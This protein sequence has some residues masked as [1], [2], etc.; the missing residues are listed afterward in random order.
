MRRFLRSTLFIGSPSSR[1]GFPRSDTGWL[2]PEHHA[3]A[4]DRTDP[5][6]VLFPLKVIPKTQI[7]RHFIFVMNSVLAISVREIIS[8]PEEGTERFSVSCFMNRLC[9]FTRFLPLTA[10]L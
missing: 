4:F 9:P 5:H 6:K 8:E 2:R 1:V 7:G 10:L 3:P